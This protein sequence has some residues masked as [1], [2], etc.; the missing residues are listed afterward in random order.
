MPR[1]RRTEIQRIFGSS[2]GRERDRAVDM[3][4]GPGPAV[5]AADPAGGGA[6]AQR[7][8]NDGLEGARASA[9]FGAATEA[10]IDLLG[11]A[12]QVFRG[13]H[14]TADIVVGQDVTGTNN[15]ENDQAPR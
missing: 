6:G 12:R 7:F 1:G 4:V 3:R 14:S 9:T 13:V 8:V 11:T 15:H 10:A 2:G 5:R